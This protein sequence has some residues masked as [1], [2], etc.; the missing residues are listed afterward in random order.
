MERVTRIE[1]ALSAWEADV[2]P[3]NYT[4]VRRRP[5]PVSGRS[6]TLPHARSPVFAPVGPLVVP[7]GGCGC[8]GSGLGRTVGAPKRVCA[9]AECRLESRLF[10]PVLWLLSSG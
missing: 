9:R 5:Q 1:L 7:G 10:H 6:L 4:R 3:L 2:L 8:G